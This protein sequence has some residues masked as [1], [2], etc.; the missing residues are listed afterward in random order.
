[1][2]GAAGTDSARVTVTGALRWVEPARPGGRPVL[3]AELGSTDGRIR[4]LWLGRERIPGI[5]PGRTLAV[6]G[7]LSV[8]QGR[9]TMFNPRYDLAPGQ[10]AAAQPG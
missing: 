4:L 7:T 1:V 8:Q 3:E 10:A 2:P 5:E 6:T 9:L